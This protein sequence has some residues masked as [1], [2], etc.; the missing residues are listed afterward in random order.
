MDTDRV[1]KPLLVALL[2]TEISHIFCCALPTLFS[3]MS[4]AAGL[5][6][7][8]AMP[9]GLE[10][11][12]AALHDWEIPLIVLSGAVVT[13]GWILHELSRRID[14]RSTGCVH[15]SCSPRK[16]RAHMVLKIASGLFL[17]NVS[18]FAFFH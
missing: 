15:E 18:V 7:V 16:A 10:A 5:G 13:F 4:L 12:H 6:L 9:P 17:L 11:L 2:A 1:Q 14:C 3:L 8:A